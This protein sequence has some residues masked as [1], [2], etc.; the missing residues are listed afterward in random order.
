VLSIRPFTKSDK[1]VFGKTT[2]SP[3]P[4]AI[5]QFARTKPNWGHSADNPCLGFSKFL[6]IYLEFASEIRCSKTTTFLA[7]FFWWFCLFICSTILA[8]VWIILYI[9]RTWCYLPFTLSGENN[10]PNPLIRIIP[11]FF[12]FIILCAEKRSQLHKSLFCV[13][14]LLSG[15]MSNF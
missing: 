2:K 4:F 1:L 5:L 15:S 8:S 9:W 6:S 3:K 14:I 12:C 11:K 10:A 13:Q 7:V